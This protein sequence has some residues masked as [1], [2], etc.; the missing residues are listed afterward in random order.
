MSALRDA[1]RR[2][3]CARRDAM[4]RRDYRTAAWALSAL[5]RIRAE[6]ALAWAQS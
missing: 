6:M 1:E 4:E 5:E 3:E 2:Y